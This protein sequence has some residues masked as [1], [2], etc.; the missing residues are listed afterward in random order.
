MA[1]ALLCTLII[2]V[3]VMLSIYGACSYIILCLIKLPLIDTWQ[4]WSQ[5]VVLIIGTD[6]ILGL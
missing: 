2:L 3:C 5:A 4:A 1:P 6:W